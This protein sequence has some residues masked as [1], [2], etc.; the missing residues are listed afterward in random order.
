MATP[1]TWRGGRLKELHK[2]GATNVCDNFRALLISYHR[3]KAFTSLL[4]DA[5]RKSYLDYVHTEQCGCI[6]GRGTDFAT[7]LVRSFIDDCRLLSLSYFILFLD[8]EKAFD[9][10]IRELLLG[11]PSGL[12]AD[13]VT[14]ITNLGLSHDVA[15]SI[16]HDIISKGQ[17][18]EQICVPEHIVKLMTSLHSSSWFSYGTLQS[19][20]LTRI[21]GRQG[22]MLGDLIL[23]LVYERALRELRD[24]LRDNGLILQV[25]PSSPEPF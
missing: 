9:R 2:K 6:P 20:I 4:K 3:G 8:L 16:V 10:V 14:Y 17:F 18:L 19:V 23:N 11:L 13:A 5:S 1:I 12:N 24:Q 25:L 21:G 7:H 22:C 15:T